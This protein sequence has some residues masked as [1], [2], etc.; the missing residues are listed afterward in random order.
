MVRD[1]C[2][3][4]FF[5]NLFVILFGLEAFKFKMTSS[6]ILTPEYFQLSENGKLACEPGVENRYNRAFEGVDPNFS[7]NKDDKSDGVIRY[8][9]GEEIKFYGIQE[10]KRSDNKKESI[11]SRLAQSLVYIFL[12]I[13]QYPELKQKFKFIILPTDK[14][15]NIVYLDRLLDSVFWTEFCFYYDC[16]RNTR[17]GKAKTKGSASNFYTYSYDV[18]ALIMDYFNRI[19]IS[20][21]Q[22]QEEFDFKIVVE[23]ILNNCL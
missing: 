12:W 3:A 21:Y 6:F 10:C 11:Y 5:C 9:V 17:Y 22:I 14:V 19:R 13:E 7:V 15:I 1:N 16:H 20:E 23:E 4:Y 2:L 8:K 18:R